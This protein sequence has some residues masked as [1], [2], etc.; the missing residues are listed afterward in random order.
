MKKQNVNHEKKDQN[1]VR[2]FLSGRGPNPIPENKRHKAGPLEKQ[3]ILESMQDIAEQD[4]ANSKRRSPDVEETLMTVMRLVSDNAKMI[5]LIQ[6][7]RCESVSDLA[8]AMGRELPNVSR[9]LSRMAAYGLIGFKEDDVDARSKK[10]MWLLPVLPNHKT[11]DWISVYC[12][13]MALQ[14]GGVAGL[15]S[16]N[17]SKMER[18]VKDA[19]A[20][21]AEKISRMRSPV[22]SH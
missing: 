2:D 10:P 21:T 13:L 16:F 8:D 14:D 12:F 5:Q 15:G 6:S 17:F 7:G 3:F 1:L 22:A 11:L 9:T 19:V 4:I 18:V 20:S